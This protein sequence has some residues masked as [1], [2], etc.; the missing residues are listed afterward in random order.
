MRA[1][2][3]PSAVIDDDAEDVDDHDDHKEDDC[4]DED[5]RSARGVSRNG[6]RS[7][8]ASLMG[9]LGYHMSGGS[10]WLRGSLGGASR[11]ASRGLP[12]GFQAGFQGV[13]GDCSVAF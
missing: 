13:R 4:D 12:E 5:R 6:R 9:P 10:P 1:R 2:R 3:K 8:L 11:R 7:L